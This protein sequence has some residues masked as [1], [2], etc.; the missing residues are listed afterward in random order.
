VQG[1][2]IRRIGDDRIIKVCLGL[3][4][5][6]NLFVDSTSRFSAT[7]ITTMSRIVGDARKGEHPTG[8]PL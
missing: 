1:D 6:K 4:V 5:F 2:L 3:D 7:S 8:S